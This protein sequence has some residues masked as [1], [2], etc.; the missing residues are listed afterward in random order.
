[1]QNLLSLIEFNKGLNFETIVTC[2][3]GYLLTL[4][5]LIAL[6]IARDAHKRY[7]R[8]LP[9]LIWFVAVFILNI[10]AW[11][12][13]LIVRPDEWSNSSPIAM[14]AG[15]NIPMANFVD[16]DNKL[17]MGIQ[18][19]INAENLTQAVKDMTVDVNWVSEDPQK[20]NLDSSSDSILAGAK[21]QNSSDVIRP[22]GLLS[23]LKTKLQNNR[24]K[25]TK[26]FNTVSV[27]LPEE[28]ADVIAPVEAVITENT[29]PEQK[30]DQVKKFDRKKN[31]ANRVENKVVNTVENKKV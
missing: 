31:R 9:A 22:S 13:Y 20:K 4:W 21:V 15:M 16:K 5:L 30:L 7:G 28:K 6:W 19:H 14:N 26:K 8:K 24:A 29:T 1:M 10:P 17:V 18:L 3:L 11:M 12:L 27:K 23:K 25:L 2:F